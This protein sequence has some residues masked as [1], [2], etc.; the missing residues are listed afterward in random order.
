[1]SAAR[2]R[3]EWDGDGGDGWGGE[4]DDAPARP[5]K[6]QMKREMTALQDLGR[7]LAGLPAETLRGMDMPPVLLAALEDFRAMVK[8]EA[9]RRQLQYIG[10]LMREA[11]AEALRAALDAAR[12]PG[13]DAAREQHRLERLRDELLDG[14]PEAV[15]RFVDQCPG[16][17]PRKLAHLVREAQK[18]RAENRPPKQYRALFRYLRE[19]GCG[20]DG[21]RP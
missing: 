20:A 18:E 14:G 10:K 9:R 2:R 7:E 3:R 19:L 1:M 5:S 16:A 8:H 15:G 21:D 17:E 4:W 13:R 12:E 11:D 6:S